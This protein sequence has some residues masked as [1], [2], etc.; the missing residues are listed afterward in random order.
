MFS[1]IVASDESGGIGLEH[2]G[3][4]I[5]SLPWTS[6]PAGKLDM[7]F[8]SKMTMNSIV[9][10]GRRTFE[11]IGQPLKTRLNIV[12]TSCKREQLLARMPKYATNPELFDNDSCSAANTAWC[13]VDS[14]DRALDLAGSV[15][16]IHGGIYV[17]GGAQILAVTITDLRLRAVYWSR[18]PGQYDCNVVLPPQFI[19]T[20]REFTPTKAN[21]PADV[22]VYTLS[23]R[24]E[25]TYKK[26][27]RR[28][29]NVPAIDNRT[30]IPA[31]TVFNQ[32]FEW[33]LRDAGR[34]VLPLLTLKYTPV[35]AITSE[36][37]WLLSGDQHID[38]LSADRV[39]IWDGNTSAEFLAGR[40]L[41]YPP[42]STGPVY[43]AQWRGRTRPLPGKIID[44]RATLPDGRIADIVA[45]DQLAAVIQAIKDDPYS[46]RHV[47]V[48]WNAA[49]I[50]LMAL[51]PC[52]YAMQFYV[53]PDIG[54][55][56]KPD[57]SKPKWLSLVVTMRSCDIALGLPF[58]AA[59][60]GILTHMIAFYCGM[61][62]RKLSINTTNCH[63]YADHV[64]G[65]REML[66]R[67]SFRPA[68]FLML[69]YAEQ[70]HSMESA[71]ALDWLADN[72]SGCFSI[73][74]RSHPRI[75]L[76][77]AI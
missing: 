12:I 70:I 26:V 8:F 65:A 20:L 39:R 34:T 19:R 32:H 69:P 71:D 41:D 56:G 33:F 1:I 47:V 73:A 76:A 37:K 58:N 29:L 35:G 42:G 74:Y 61:R 28:L 53:E 68:R 38:R 57:E 72:L 40:G 13:V 6:T 46:R 9:I 50:H 75:Q 14:I 64:D 43:G 10:M 67:E 18:I 15:S 11:A 4:P 7:A 49:D 30:G 62:A 59:S 25:Q 60:Y 63:L 17:I 5:G 21:D 36:L 52:H 27:L 22:D 66:T 24:G 16:Y 77:M 31:H 23:N 55:D 44:D 48:A 45:P 2:D 3:N 54:A 51:P